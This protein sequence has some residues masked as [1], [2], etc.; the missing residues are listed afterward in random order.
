[1]DYLLQAKNLTRRYKDNIALDDFSINI[2]KGS[3][4]GLLDQMVQEKQLLF[5]LLIKLQHPT[6]AKSI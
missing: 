5:V 2:P 4:Y 1:M 6:V 3:I